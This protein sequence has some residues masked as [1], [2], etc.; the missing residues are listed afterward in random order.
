MGISI[1]L[2]QGAQSDEESKMDS[3]DQ[4]SLALGK[5]PVRAWVKRWVLQPNVLELNQGDIWV[6]KWV[7]AEKAQEDQ[8][9]LDK[10]AA[11]IAKE[12]E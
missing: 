9:K 7:R 2:K 3:S 8:E 5:R 6:Q 10:L 12:Q 4:N 11:D 1:R